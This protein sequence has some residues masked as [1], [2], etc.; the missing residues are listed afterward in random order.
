MILLFLEKN[1]IGKEGDE[2]CYTFTC[3]S[4]LV[5]LLTA[6]TVCIVIMMLDS[7]FSASVSLSL[8]FWEEITSYVCLSTEG[9][10]VSSRMRIDDGS[11]FSYGLEFTLTLFTT[12]T[13]T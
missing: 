13:T 10:S 7:V 11:Y 9:S 3:P 2:T 12:H 1:E 5:C 4:V 8:S 6:M